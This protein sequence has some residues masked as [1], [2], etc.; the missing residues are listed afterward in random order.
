MPERAYSIWNEP[1]Y[2]GAVIEIT[3]NIPSMVEISSGYF[4]SRDAIPKVFSLLRLNGAIED[5]ARSGVQLML[6]SVRIAC[7]GPDP[8]ERRQTGARAKSPQ[9]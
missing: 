1:K 6:R 5:C 4:A 7:G 2:L 8:D 3:S 9:E